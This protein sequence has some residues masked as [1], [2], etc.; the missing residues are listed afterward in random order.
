ML[1]S[2]KEAI[3]LRF[4]DAHDDPIADIKYL[5]HVGTI[6][7][8]QN[9]FNKLISR[10]ELP[11]DQPISFYIV[12]LQNDVELAVRM[13]RPKTLDEVPGHSCRGQVFNL[14]VVADDFDTCYEDNGIVSSEGEVHEEATWDIIEYSPHISLHA[15][16]GVESFQ[17][18]RVTGHVGKHHLHNLI[19][20]GNTHNF[21]NINKAKQLGCQLSSTCPLQ[22]DIAG[23]AKVRYDIDN[24][25][26]VYTR[27]PPTH[28]D[29]IEVIVKELLESRV[30]RLSQSPFSSPVVMV[31]KKDAL[32]N[33]VFK[34]YLRK[35]VLVFFD[36]ILVYSRDLKTHAKH[37]E[38]VL[39]LLRQ[40][41]LFAKQ[42]KCVF[43]ANK[44]KYL[45]HVITG[46]WVATDETKIK[47]MKQ[48]PVPSNLKK[49][50][51][52]LGLT[53][54][55]RRF[56]RSYASISQPLTK[57][58][59]KNAFVWSEEAQSSFLNLKEV[60]ISA[61]LLK[62][63][64]FDEQF[65]VETNASR[66]GIRAIDHFSL[67]YLLE[68]RITTPSQ[69]KWLPKLI[70]FDYEIMC[71]KGSENEVTDALSRVYTGGQLIQIVLSTVTTSLLPKIVESWST[72]TV[73]ATMIK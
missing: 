69:M 17:T 39:L 55:Y 60:M 6:E 64:N 16:N 62:L 65:V 3:L 46:A 22:V 29:A 34:Q 47:A 25:M 37:L 8:Y 63:P 56:I 48:W 67:K 72:D 27:H 15:L 51:G 61:P 57:L 30:I 49:L 41:T 13:F 71:K 59:K 24:S 4:D 28:K 5:R 45:C 19:D 50:R 73:L 52:F 11:K 1:N 32:M 10:V 33:Y 40:H 31:K 54:Y 26:V 44:V 36:E 53:C 2:F 18:I 12:G 66:E 21:L 70:G 7:E 42:S 38:I 9:A 43:R 14:E 35:F 68:Q 23:D 58:M 20:I